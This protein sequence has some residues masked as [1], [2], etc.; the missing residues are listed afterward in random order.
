MSLWNGPHGRKFIDE[1]RASLKK[2]NEHSA[3]FVPANRQEDFLGVFGEIA[4]NSPGAVRIIH[5]QLAHSILDELEPAFYD[6]EYDSPK[7]GDGLVKDS[8]ILLLVP[9]AEHL[10][11][12]SDFFVFAERM[13][14]HAKSCRDNAKTMNWSILYLLQPGWIFPGKDTGLRHFH[15][16]G[17]L[18]SSDLEYAIESAIY[19]RKY[20]YPAYHWLYALCRGLCDGSA[21][22]VPRVIDSEPASF[23]EI[24]D[25]LAEHE[26]NKPD[27]RAL[28]QEY[29]KKN[30]NYQL[31]R[32][33]LPKN[34]ALDLWQAG[35]IEINSH[36]YPV[37]HPAA[38]LAAGYKSSVKKNIVAGQIQVYLPLTQD[39]FRLICNRM[40]HK[41]G[42]NWDTF[43]NGKSREISEI[44][45]LFYH[46]QKR[47]P[48][49]AR[50]EYELAG[51]WRDVRNCLAHG[52]I[53]PVA[54]AFKA[55]SRYELIRETPYM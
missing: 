47:Y 3:V 33:S 20:D 31:S 42:K 22:L 34:E 30:L 9:R 25:I 36:G 1:I 49:D 39:V 54:L 52:H 5:L 46:I 53:L 4:E 38:M 14:A 21:D 17:Q 51:L 16:W 24:E 55:V 29:I 23:D 2:G 50:E 48:L 44:G 12:G 13:S 10:Q 37:I 6:E 43:E 15:W 27:I 26:L 41:F 32:D 7:S 35:A 18:F 11:Q 19:E 40:R 45:P 8:K 28:V